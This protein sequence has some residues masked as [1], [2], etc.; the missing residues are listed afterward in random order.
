MRSQL[1]GLSPISEDASWTHYCWQVGVHPDAQWTTTVKPPVTSLTPVL[2]HADNLRL[3]RS[4][5][6]VL[7]RIGEGQFGVVR[8]VW[9][10]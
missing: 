3:K 6:D 1:Q 10:G 2:Q 5:F 7:G 8:H 4:D 9:L